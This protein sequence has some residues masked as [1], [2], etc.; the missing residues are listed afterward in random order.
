MDFAVIPYGTVNQEAYSSLLEE[1][2][3]ATPFHSLDWMRIYE[4]FS[5]TARQFLVCAQE[6]ETL[7]AAMPV[8]VFEKFFVRAVFSSGF[9]VHGGPICRPDC[10]SE[11]VEG[12]LKTFAIY[13]A[14]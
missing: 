3:G 12:L 5:H 9:G 11:V 4:L 2:P 8:T 13:F 7:L 10:E 1:C 14:G 6:G